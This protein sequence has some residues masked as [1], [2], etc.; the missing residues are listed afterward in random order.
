VNGDGF[1]DVIVGAF[2]YGAAA[3]LYGLAL[4]Y[5][6]NT[7]D[8][9][10][11]PLRGTRSSGGGGGIYLPRQQ[12]TSGGTIALGGMSDESGSFRL[13]AMGR[14][15]AGSE[16]ARLEWQ[17]EELGTT[18]DG[19]TVH[20]GDWQTGGT[21]GPDSSLIEF[22]EVVSGLQSDTP[23]HWRLRVGFDSPVQPH[24]HWVTLSPSVPS[25]M[26]LRTSP[27]DTKVQLAED[28]ATPAV[29]SLA[30]VRPNPFNA[31]AAIQFAMPEAGEARLVIY[32]VIGRLVRVLADRRYD[33][34]A[35]TEIWRG[36]DESGHKVG[37]GVYLVRMKAGDFEV[38]RK[39][40]L[41][42]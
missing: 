36:D 21:A 30:S 42:E 37:P 39:M 4:T 18:L 6:G 16:Y 34:G 8:G 27:I 1:G 7:P 15:P 11:S 14:P 26:Q 9:P 25:M 32:D 12:H 20:H 24:T 31:T 41:V 17:I 2:K 13:L 40:V 10:G 29:V 28:E 35:H 22:D 19:A 38:S 33:A 5:H 3:P 23:Y